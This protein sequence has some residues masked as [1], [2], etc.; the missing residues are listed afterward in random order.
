MRRLSFLLLAF[1]TVTGALSS[2]R[3]LSL[4]SGEHWWGGAAGFGTQMPFDGKSKVV[5]EL[6]KSNYDNPASPFLISDYG[7]SVWCTKP[8]RF[9]F[10]EGSLSIVCSDGEIIV[11]ENGKT[12]SGAFRSVAKRFVLENEIPDELLF[13]S[14]QYN[15]WIELT[16]NQ[17]ERDIL[18]YAQSM[19]DHGLPPGVLMI[20][21]TWQE[22]YGMWY[23]SPRRFQNPKEMCEKLHGQGFKIMLWMC[24]FVSMDSPAYRDIVGGLHYKGPGGFVANKA[25]AWSN[26][27]ATISWWNGRS[28]MLDFTHPNAGAWYS[29]VLQRLMKDYG[30]DGFK[31]DGGD[32]CYYTRGTMAFDVAATAVD[33]AAAYGRFPLASRVSEYRNSYANCGKPVAVRLLDKGHNWEA[34]GKL[35]PD[36]LATGLTGHPFVCPDMIGGGDFVAF[37]PGSTFD[38][39]LFIRSAQIHALA[40]MMQFSASPWRVLSEA[41]QVAVK[42]AVDIRRLFAK[43]IVAIAHASGSTGEPMM[44]CMEY[45]FPKCGYSSISDQFMMGDKLLVAPQT[46][47][48]A[49]S[50][51]VVIPPGK[52][53]SD[54]G[55]TIEGPCIVEEQTPIN[56]L[57]YY[58]RQSFSGRMAK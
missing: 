34:L 26:D 23:F 35:I 50:R 25:K 38:E 55:K 33:Q 15:T 20:D 29:G 27:P 24:P 45:V 31:F 57:P 18:A 52:W 51:K 2:E 47:K 49:Q 40:P 13:S 53:A 37:L 7:R 46:K 11:D 22:D 54:E 58:I 9:T 30:I 41:G 1:S 21:D 56:R 3:T 39:E 14:P 8:P 19:I 4:L 12:L 48:G 17:N 28:A 36:M 16:Y 42:K 10:S 6:D 5:M 44:R 43:D 32:I